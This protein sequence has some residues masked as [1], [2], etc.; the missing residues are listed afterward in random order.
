MVYSDRNT[1]IDWIIEST[2]I[3]KTQT[4]WLEK[5]KYIGHPIRLL[6]FFNDVEAARCNTTR[7]LKKSNFF[8]ICLKKKE[9]E[10]INLEGQVYDAGI[11]D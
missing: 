7:I 10:D 2:E 6:T 8:F 3:K 1:K 11:A 5:E 4:F 9:E